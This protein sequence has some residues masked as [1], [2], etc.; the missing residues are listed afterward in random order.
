VWAA[1]ANAATRQTGV[2]LLAAADAL[3]NSLPRFLS[4]E[5]QAH[6][7]AIHTQTRFVLDAALFAAAWQRGQTMSSEQA[8]ALA[9]ASPLPH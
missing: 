8:I 3:F 1:H 6:Y 7:Q 2:Q 4:D 9:L 5:Q